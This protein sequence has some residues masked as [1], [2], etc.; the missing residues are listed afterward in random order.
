MS[1][2]LA[3]LNGEIVTPGGR[4]RANLGIQGGRIA[5]IADV[6]DALTSERPYKSAWSPDEAREAI[7]EASGTHFD[8]DCVTAFLTR[9]D[10]VMKIISAGETDPGR[11]WL[12]VA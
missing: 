5:A 4:Y 8:P 3:V 11:D 9:W 2:D 6:F 7:I 12:V 10:D 1:Y